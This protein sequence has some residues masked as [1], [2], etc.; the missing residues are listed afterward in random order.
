MFTDQR[1]IANCILNSEKGIDFGTGQI[2]DG[3]RDQ[4]SAY[5][6]ISRGTIVLESSRRGENKEERYVRRRVHEEAGG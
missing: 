2:S 6:V 3:A 4:Q 1:Y 5:S